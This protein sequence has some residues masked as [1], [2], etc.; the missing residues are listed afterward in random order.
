MSI[1][2]WIYLWAFY[3]VPLIYISLFVPVPYCLDDCGFVVEPEV[4]QVDT[5]SSIILSQDFKNILYIKDLLIIFEE[6]ILI[7]QMF[8]FRRMIINFWL[9]GFLDWTQESAEMHVQPR[10]NWVS[11]ELFLTNIFFGFRVSMF[12]KDCFTTV[13]PLLSHQLWIDVF[14]WIMTLSVRHS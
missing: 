13:N 7:I 3:S 10:R 12:H 5:S 2:S 8:M 9:S 1:G 4:R 14:N 11:A 6:L